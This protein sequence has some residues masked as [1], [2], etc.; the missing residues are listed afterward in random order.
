MNRRFKTWEIALLFGLCVSLLCG[1]SLERER[2]ALSERVIRLHVLANSD[3][4]EDQRLKL[5]VRDAILGEVEALCAGSMDR[6]QALERLSDHL[7]A[8]AQA[9][10]AELERQGSAQ[11]VRVGLERCH[12]P[13]KRYEGFAL[14]A[15]DYTAL[16]VVLGEGQGQNWWC[17]A[18]PPLCLG[19]ASES[20]E[21]AAALGQLDEEQAR[22][23]TREEPVYLLRFKAL[24]LWDLLRESF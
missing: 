16:R 9:A 19:A 6:A 11:T 24:E 2:E 15:G 12:F 18:F 1:I 20:V 8:L 13:T 17:V 22:L 7:P 10:R 4:R 23:L 14:P 5:A 21:Q 3:A